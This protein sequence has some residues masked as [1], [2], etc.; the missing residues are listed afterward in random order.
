MR[1]KF[2]TRVGCGTTC[3]P[4]YHSTLI[5][6]HIKYRTRV[7]CGTTCQPS[8]ATRVRTDAYVR[9]LF[10]G[11][12]GVEPERLLVA[13]QDL[14]GA[15]A[16]EAPPEGAQP[17]IVAEVDAHPDEEVRPRYLVDQCD[18]PRTHAPFQPPS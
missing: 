10:R 13:R 4:E 9:I 1:V 3:Q 8:D 17:D 15:V 14:E 7:G 2:R 6:H 12:V 11:T 16:E 18:R 5:P